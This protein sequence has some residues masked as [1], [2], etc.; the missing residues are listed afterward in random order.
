[1]PLSA[2]GL[3]FMSDIGHRRGAFPVTQLFFKTIRDGDA[4]IPPYAVACD[5]DGEKSDSDAHGDVFY[6]EHERV[7]QN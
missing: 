1:M 6:D 5:S 2:T 3:L 7:E 4:K